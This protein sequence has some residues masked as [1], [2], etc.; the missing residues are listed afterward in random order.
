MKFKIIDVE[1]IYNNDNNL[2]KEDVNMLMEW[3]EK[4]PHLPKVS[5]L[6]MACFLHSCFYK[7]EAAKSAIDVYFTGSTV[8]PDMF[9]FK[10]VLQDP[11][12]KRTIDN[13]L[14]VILPKKAPNGDS[15]FLLVPSVSPENY[16]YPSQCRVLDAQRMIHLHEKGPFTGIHII[17]DLKNVVFGH[18]IKLSTTAMAVKNYLYI[19]QEGL[20]VRLKHIHFINIVSFMDKILALIKPFMKKELQEKLRVHT[21]IN[22]LY[23]YIP[24]DLLPVEYGGS[25]ES[26]DVLKENVKKLLVDNEDFLIA[27]DALVVDESKRTERNEKL[28]DVFGIAGSFKKLEVD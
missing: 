14:V 23:T 22:S 25:C 5:E 1:E 10:N 21:D 7:I 3:A 8:N 13:N 17:I 2:K 15:A 19:L 16:H 4:Q 12:V 9:Q 26:S 28:N 27:Q 11:M 18:F 20:P 6:I 24:Q